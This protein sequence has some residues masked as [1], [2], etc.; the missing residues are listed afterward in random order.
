VRRYLFLEDATVTLLTDRRRNR[1]YG[2]CGGRPG[3]AGKNL[4]FKKGKETPELLP[5]KIN[6]DV[7][8]GDSIEIR[9]PGGGGYGPLPD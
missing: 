6:I 9:T 1:P 2:L 7:N 3:K 5:D 8:G 4:F